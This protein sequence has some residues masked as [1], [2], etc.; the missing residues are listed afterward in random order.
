LGFGVGAGFDY[1]ALWPLAIVMVEPM[2]SLI[3]DL[4]SSYAEYL[5]LEI[6]CLSQQ[7]A[8]ILENLEQMQQKE[9][10][11]LLALY[12]T[13]LGDLEYRLLK[14]QIECRALQHRI[15][16]ATTKL[17]RGES[18]T[19]HHLEEFEAQTQ[20]A[21]LAWQAQ[22]KQHAEALASGLAYMQGLTAVDGNIVQRAKQAYRRLA[23]LLHPDVN[24]QYQALFEHYWP[25][26]QEAYRQVDANLL[27]ALLQIVETAVA[28]SQ[29]SKEMPEE[30]IARLKMLVEQQ[31]ERLV[32][33][34]NQPPFCWAE[35]LQDE[36]WLAE[37]H[38]TLET[39]I[40]LETQRWSQ[41]ISRH[42]DI[43]ARVQAEV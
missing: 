15:E 1:L 4:E 12:Q 34:R 8:A 30:T 28:Q 29:Q 24:P 11:Y 5:R 2:E 27:E 25:S 26:V 14:L 17:N 42:A 35:Q 32:T 31:S 21:L 19:Q 38:I 39:A 6:D 41:L 33:L 9:K 37:R 40:T 43:A 22:L 36:H 16:L 3:Q 10:P 7:L 23:R 18:L 13:K 20:Q